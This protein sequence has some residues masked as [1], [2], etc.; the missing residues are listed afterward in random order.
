MSRT[1]RMLF[2]S[3]AFVGLV[4]L[5]GRALALGNSQGGAWEAARAL[6]VEVR[7]SEALDARDAAIHR[8]NQGKQAVTE[9]VVAGRLSLAAAA[10]RFALLGDLSEG[11]AGLGA[12]K[13]PVGGP[14]VCRNV[15]TWAAAALPE[16]SSQRAVVLARLWAEYRALFGPD[17]PPV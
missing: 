9:E 11:G 4:A 14:A 12:Y 1:L 5:A 10:E 16:G 15:I 2:F 17:S 6:L 7:R 3:F 8:C 13:Q